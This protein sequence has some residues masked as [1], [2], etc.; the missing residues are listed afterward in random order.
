MHDAPATLARRSLAPAR[1]GGATAVARSGK[2][3]AQMLQT[4][5]R[6]TILR[7]RKWP[8]D[9]GCAGDRLHVGGERFDHGRAR[10]VDRAAGVSDLFP[11]HVARTGS[12]AIVL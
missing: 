12:A 9:R 2:D 3:A 11:L 6:Q 7:L 5:L 1:D 4:I 8:P 10:V